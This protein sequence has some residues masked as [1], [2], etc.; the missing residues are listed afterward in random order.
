MFY[1]FKDSVPYFLKLHRMVKVQARD[2]QEIIDGLKIAN[3]KRWQCKC[4]LCDPAFQAPKAK[5]TNK[6]VFSRS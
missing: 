2:E 4:G 5:D 3:S 6:N 1:L